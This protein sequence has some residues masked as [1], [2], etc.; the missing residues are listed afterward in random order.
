MRE[1]RF[2][3]IATIFRYG[4]DQAIIPYASPWPWYKKS[5]AWLFHWLDRIDTQLSSPITLRWILQYTW[6]TYLPDK[7]YHPTRLN[8]LRRDQYPISRIGHLKQELPTWILEKVTLTIQRSNQWSRVTPKPRSY[9]TYFSC[10]EIYKRCCCLP[11]TILSQP[12]KKL[13]YRSYMIFQL[14]KWRSW[15]LGYIH[16]VKNSQKDLDSFF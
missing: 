6:Q 11:Y 5:V 16:Q 1:R 12:T 15:P 14:H 2:E 10:S 7:L 13:A 9:H 4:T 3:Y 8:L